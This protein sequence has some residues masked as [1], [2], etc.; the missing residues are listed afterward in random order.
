MPAAN[1][2]TES[3]TPDWL[4]RSGLRLGRVWLWVASVERAAACVAVARRIIG[5]RGVTASSV[6]VGV[7]AAGY[8]R[9]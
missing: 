1:G 6:W 4:E 3:P 8:R 7:K 9:I 5:E 2:A